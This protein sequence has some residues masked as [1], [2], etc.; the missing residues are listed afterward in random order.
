[1]QFDLLFPHRLP[2]RVRRVTRPR[3]RDVFEQTKVHAH[4]HTRTL[5][6]L[7]F[8]TLCT[9]LDTKGIHEARPRLLDSLCHALSR[10]H[11]HTHT[12]TDTHALRRRS[13]RADSAS[14]LPVRLSPTTPPAVNQLKHRAS[15]SCGCLPVL[16]LAC[17]DHP[18][19]SAVLLN[20]HNLNPT[21]I[22]HTEPILTPP[23]TLPSSRSARTRKSSSAHA[24]A[25]NP[26]YS[27][28]SEVAHR[29]SPS[30]SVLAQNGRDFHDARRPGKDILGSLVRRSSAQTLPL[31]SRKV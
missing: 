27:P 21:C 19:V 24:P 29:S 31:T 10:T 30:H 25:R 1:M 17:T 15:C 22:P 4:T 16:T 23:L 6:R 5:A 9:D 14:S 12:P 18:L 3:V 8:L 2:V 28:S 26:P 7:R 11:T 20:T 13:P